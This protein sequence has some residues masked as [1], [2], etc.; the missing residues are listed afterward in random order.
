[1]D[2]PHP[3][4]GLNVQIP[5]PH[6]SIMPH[7]LSPTHPHAQH[8]MDGTTTFWVP[9][10]VSNVQAS[11]LPPPLTSPDDESHEK[12]ETAHPVT[13]LQM[14]QS[15]SH[16]SSSSSSP[17]SA[18]AGS[19]TGSPGGSQSGDL[20]PAHVLTRPFP[21]RRVHR[22]LCEQPGCSDGFNTRFS[23]KRH[24]KMHTGEKPYPCTQCPKSF[25]EK[26][27]LVRHLRIH[28]G[29]RP[30]QCTWPSCTRSFSDRTNVRR[31]EAQHELQ[32]DLPLEEQTAMMSEEQERVVLKK[33]E[34]EGLSKKKA[35]RQQA[36]AEAAAHAAAEKREQETA[37]HKREQVEEEIHGPYLSHPE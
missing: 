24:L 8:H 29:E 17:G 10:Q 25:A 23:L 15:S 32:K 12:A 7:H 30:F 4:L 21:P 27:T 31:H 28:T 37:Q 34:Q 13:L 26:S 36:A 2:F 22:F 9:I 18:S 20:T 33:K 5:P 16:A 1:M 11:P 3:S 35:E 19:P 14:T 6:P